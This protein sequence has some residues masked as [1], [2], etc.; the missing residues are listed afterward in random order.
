MQCEYNMNLSGEKHKDLAENWN[1]SISVETSVTVYKLLPPK[2]SR[3]TSND[4]ICQVTSRP[5]FYDELHM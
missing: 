2:S 4:W 5:T 1:T 3:P